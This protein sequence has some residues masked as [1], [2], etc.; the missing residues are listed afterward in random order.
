MFSKRI[1][2]L[3]FIF[4]IFQH[5]EVVSL[6]GFPLTMGLVVGL[7]LVLLVTPR[8]P[9][10]PLTAALALVVA[11]SGFAAVATPS[12][13]SAEYFRTLGLFLLCA[14]II[15]RA[16]W[17]DV[18]PLLNISDISS[19][20]FVALVFVATMSVLQVVTGYL[21]SVAFFNPFGSAQYLYQYKPHIEFVEFPRAQGFFL[22]PSYDAFVIGSLTTALLCLGKRQLLSVLFGAIGLLACQSATGLIIFAAVLVVVAIRSGPAIR[23]T[24]LVLVSATLVIAGS[25]V[26]GRLDSIGTTSTSANYRIL[27]PL[28]V[29][30]DTLLNSPF[31][32]PL[33]SVAKTLSTYGLQN[34]VTQGTSLDN[35]L[36]VL[37]F[38]FGWTGL[39]AVCAWALFTVVIVARRLSRWPK[40]NL[41][42]IAPIWIF[43]SMLFSGGI[44]LPEFAIGTWLVIICFRASPKL[45]K[46]E[47]DSLELE[48]E[49]E[50]SDRNVSRSGGLRKDARF[51]GT[52]PFARRGL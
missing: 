51:S 44:M 24:A 22:E 33:G 32:R 52:A 45:T 21:G 13:D 8:T 50:H 10:G 3:A 23:L 6:G 19:G 12:V 15:T 41:S 35:G 43:L 4:V 39:I 5:F 36:Y 48:A 26:I 9:Y 25:T 17:S 38:Y 20:L 2:A 42:W 49:A 37:V 16:I 30:R 47:G 29:L 14:F 34:G 11:L 7:L 27:A 46:T 31:G 40:N 28:E 1:A 18:N